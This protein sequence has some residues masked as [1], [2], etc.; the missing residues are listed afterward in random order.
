M[1]KT[2][3]CYSLLS[4][5]EIDNLLAK[6]SQKNHFIRFPL[7]KNIPKKVLTSDNFSAQRIK[8]ENMPN[9]QMAQMMK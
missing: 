7:L 3:F 5:L 4:L 6:H 1:A 9:C 8:K 2:S